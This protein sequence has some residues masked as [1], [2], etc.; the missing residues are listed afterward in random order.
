MASP[1]TTAQSDAFLALEQ[2]SL[3]T[4]EIANL[5]L[6]LV[7]SMDRVKLSKAGTLESE[8]AAI[9]FHAKDAERIASIDSLIAIS[10]DSSQKCH[11]AWVAGQ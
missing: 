8:N 4:A 9:A 3:H 7:E 1:L 2:L 5:L 6:E 11:A 10:L